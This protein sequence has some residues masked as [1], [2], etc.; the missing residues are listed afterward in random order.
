MFDEDI[1]TKSTAL[2]TVRTE[3]PV[4]HAPSLRFESDRGVH[5]S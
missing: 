3:G 1:L 4:G 5:D 2:M